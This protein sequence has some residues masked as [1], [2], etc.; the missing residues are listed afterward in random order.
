MHI[1]H[2]LAVLLITAIA[3]P[4]W[5]QR[6]AT[7]AMQNILK[8][9]TEW[10]D[11]AKQQA[12]PNSSKGSL[13][14]FTETDVSAAADIESEVHAAIN[15]TD[16]ANII[17]S[18]N[19]VSGTANSTNYIYYTNDFGASW[20]KSSFSTSPGVPNAFILGG[21]DPMFAFD[22][23][24]KAYFSWINLYFS[25]FNVNFDLFWA[26]STTNGNSWVRETND[27][28]G[29]ATGLASGFDKQWMEVDRNPASPYYGNLYCSFFE[30]NGTTNET[31]I[32]VRTKAAA[33]SAFTQTTARI[34]DNTY[35]FVQFSSLTVDALGKVHVSFFGSQDSVN[36]ALYHSVS[37]DGAQNFSTPNKISDVLIP[38][39]SAGL[40]ASDSLFGVTNA[41]LYPCPYMIADQ[42]N[43]P[44]ANNLY[45]VWS[46]IGTLT[47]NTTGF[48]V[49][50]SRSTDGGNTWSQ[51]QILNGAN[52]NNLSSDQF[53]PSIGISP[54][55]RVVVQWYDR[56]DDVQNKSA[57][58]YLTY[59]D[60][61]G[62]TFAPD[63]KVTDQS[64]DFS[65][66]GSQN[67]GFGIGEYNAILATD[68][69]ILPVWSD[70][71]TNDGDLDLKMAYVNVSGVNTDVEY[72]NT[73]T[74]KLKITNIG[75]NPANDK[76]NYS[77]E[78]TKPGKLNV[79][80]FDLKGALIIQTESNVN[81]GSNGSFIATNQ[82]SAGTY[83]VKFTYDGASITRK[84]NVSH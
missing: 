6:T 22:A 82:I 40:P 63:I 39:F 70:G 61:G 19:Y 51:A 20:T 81:T 64:M 80:V 29:S 58:I 76:L 79:Q 50:L 71:R 31:Y 47:N 43:G 55:G 28:I 10:R 9:K 75:P 4:L 68:N 52:V 56:R 48:D 17:V 66:A 77:I 12:H 37:T 15:P 53:Y 59:S 65:Q 8:E 24:G 38:R 14:S 18:S 11:K 78:V 30:I 7:Q 35:K 1:K 84:I 83:F 13:R 25:G 57:H 44:Y 49:Y 23:S 45:I 16:T 74:D 72:I 32:G 54:L 36:Y 46:S 42:T 5:A 27:N 67:G 3:V 73:L 41:R 33:V 62:A 60:N 21:G 2:V 69:Y 26:S 34:T